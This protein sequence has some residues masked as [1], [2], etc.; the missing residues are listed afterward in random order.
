MAQQQQA[1]QQQTPA[2]TLGPGQGHNILNFS[3]AHNVKTY[4]KAI[5]SSLLRTALMA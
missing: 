3:Q 4:Y 2:F 5:T 1:Q